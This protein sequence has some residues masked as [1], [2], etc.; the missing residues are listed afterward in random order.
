[1][2]KKVGKTGLGIFSSVHT[3]NFEP[4]INV[5]SSSLN[6]RQC[7]ICKHETC[8][9]QTTFLEASLTPKPSQLIP[10][11]RRLDEVKRQPS[12]HVQKHISLF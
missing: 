12:V 6:D 3:H 7:L 2:L 8:Y 1:M 5:G 9:V 4:R 10:D 11:R